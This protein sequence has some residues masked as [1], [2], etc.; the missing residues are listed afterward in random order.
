MGDLVTAIPPVPMRLP[1]ADGLPARLVDVRLQLPP[2]QHE[3]GL[4]VDTPL[5]LGRTRAR[6]VIIPVPGVA[7]ASEMEIHPFIYGRN[8]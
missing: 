7:Q 8:G 3:V 1:G 5:P 4:V 6:L 2:S